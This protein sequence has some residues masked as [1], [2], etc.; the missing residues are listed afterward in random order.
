MTSMWFGAFISKSLQPINHCHERVV[1]EEVH[2]QFTYGGI[3]SVFVFSLH[4]KKSK[5]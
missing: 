4:K 1:I 5:K 2:T 3:E